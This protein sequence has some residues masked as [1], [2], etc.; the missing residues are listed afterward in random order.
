MFLDWCELLGKL[1]RSSNLIGDTNP[2]I[3]QAYRDLTAAQGSNG[4]LDTKTRELIAL[5]VAVT[6]RCD[7]CISAHAAAAVHAGATR[8]EVSDA[9]GTAIALNAGA[10]YVYSLHA[11]EAIQSLTQVGS[12][13][14]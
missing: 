12:N 7:G 4:A 8:A 3:L 1:K 14:G 9:L 2:G 6:T 10:A 11:M 13:G 5:A